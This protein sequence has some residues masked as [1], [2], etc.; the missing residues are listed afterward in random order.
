MARSAWAPAALLSVALSFPGTGSVTPAGG[1]TVAV[2]LSAPVVPAGTIPLTA[3]VAWVPTGNVTSASM[4]PVPE[5]LPHPAP[6]P[7]AVHVQVKPAS[8]A[9]NASWTCAFV[10]FDGPALFTT[11]V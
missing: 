3:N 8:G 11:M 1:V 2:L 9:G 5:A 10:T 6:A 7:L 4:L